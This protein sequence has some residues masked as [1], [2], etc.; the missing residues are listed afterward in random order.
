MVPDGAT[1][2]AG[3][4]EAVCQPPDTGPEAGAAA[5]TSEASS[6]PLDAA[7]VDGAVNGVPEAV[8][9]PPDAVLES[10]AAAGAS[11]AV[12]RPPDAVNAGA[13]VGVDALVAP[14][15]LYVGQCQRRLAGCQDGRSPERKGSKGRGVCIQRNRS[16]WV[17]GR[18]LT[19][20]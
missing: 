1:G 14:L 17:D 3:A 12:S 7:L 20:D 16:G 5:G 11:E 6:W 10:G 13:A 19:R 2:T 4:A 15:R 18:V 9:R 8:G